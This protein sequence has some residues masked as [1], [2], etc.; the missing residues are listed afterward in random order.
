MDALDFDRTNGHDD[1]PE[2]NVSGNPGFATI[3]ARRYG[4]R[5]V[6]KGGV[7]VAVSTLLTGRALAAPVNGGQPAVAQGPVQRPG[8]VPGFA[9]VPH[10]TYSTPFLAAPSGTA[11]RATARK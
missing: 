4:R 5:E 11:R 9:P 7:A 1:E 8:V 2:C 10:S 3:V 6:V